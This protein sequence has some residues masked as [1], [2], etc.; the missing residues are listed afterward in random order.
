MVDENPTALYYTSRV[1]T[2][3]RIADHDHHYT[4]D[5]EIWAGGGG[6]VK[7]SKEKKE[8]TEQRYNSSSTLEYPP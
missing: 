4:R 1:R 7:Q 8:Q 6:G 3:V 5:R 2:A